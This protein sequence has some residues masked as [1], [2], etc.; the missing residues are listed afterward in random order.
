MCI[1]LKSW[2][3]LKNDAKIHET[4]KT[5]INMIIYNFGVYHP[6]HANFSGFLA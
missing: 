5:A 1:M 3:N 2:I 4:Y 6:L